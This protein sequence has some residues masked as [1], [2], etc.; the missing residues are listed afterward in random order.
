VSPLDAYV[1]AADSTGVYTSKLISQIFPDLAIP[2]DTASKLKMHNNGYNPLLYGNGVMKLHVKNFIIQNGLS[3]SDF[4]ILDNAPRG[5]WALHSLHGEPTTC[6][7]V[8]DKLF[9]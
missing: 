5:I 6:S 4:R 3:M 2:F 1:C 8:I 9:Y 7:R